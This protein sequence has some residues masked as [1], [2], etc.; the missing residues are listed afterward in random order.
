MAIASRELAVKQL[1]LAFAGGT[2]EASATAHTVPGGTAIVATADMAGLDAGRLTAMLGAEAGTIAGRLD[3]GA[4]LEM[5]GDTLKDALA[6]SHGSAVLVMTEGSVARALLERASTN[7]AALFRTKKG[8]APIKCLLGVIDLA[9]GVGA[10]S[11]L[12]LR[13]AAATLIGGGQ[14]DLRRGR[15]DVTI[16]SD[17]AST[18]ALALDIPFRVSGPL[19]RPH[20]EP[21]IG[22]SP[23]WLKPP[24]GTDPLR[25]LPP[26]LR[27]LAARCGAL[28]RIVA[29]GRQHR[30]TRSV[31]ASGRQRFAQQTARAR[32]HRSKLRAIRTSSRESRTDTDSREREEKKP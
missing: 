5:T 15:L 24:P 31:V 11:P 2:V 8:A 10:I 26:K 19:A 23:S 12:R 7:L 27:E 14:I 32:T 1:S 21:L 3:G 13:T 22:A 17:P 9:G 28:R 20:V 25:D 30:A 16:R 4:A 18:G 6:E 29:G